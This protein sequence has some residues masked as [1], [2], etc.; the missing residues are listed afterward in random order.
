MCGCMENIRLD[1][2]KRVKTDDKYNSLVNLRVVNENIALMFCDDNTVKSKPYMNFV[3]TGTYETRSGN[4][5]TKR[6][7]LSVTFSYCP[8][9]GERI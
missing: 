2:E 1:L 7:N 3:V 5:R 9:C 4:K 6:E 8:F